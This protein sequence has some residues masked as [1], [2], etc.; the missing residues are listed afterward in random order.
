MMQ[1]NLTVQRELWAGTVFT[2]GYNGSSGVH[3][4]DVD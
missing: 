2:I 4:F 3:L 1:Y